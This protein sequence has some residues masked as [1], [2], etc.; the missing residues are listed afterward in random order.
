MYKI[1]QYEKGKWITIKITHD[2]E[3]AAEYYKRISQLV[4]GTIK[5][6]LIDV[7]K[8]NYSEELK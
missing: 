3:K 4:K 2:I 6:R 5:I 1:E 7:I 8:D